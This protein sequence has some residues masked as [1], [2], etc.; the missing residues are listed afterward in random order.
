MSDD[1]CT[2]YWILLL[3]LPTFAM[4]AVFGWILGRNRLM[5]MAIEMS[6]ALER[7]DGVGED[8]WDTSCHHRFTL[9]DGTPSEN[10]MKFC[11]YCGKPLNEHI[12]VAEEEG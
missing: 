2:A 1:Y 7:S 4:G 11:C 3:S 6:Q 10:R 8:H 5:K 12:A 9:N